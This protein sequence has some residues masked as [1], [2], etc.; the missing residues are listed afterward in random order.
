MEK[1]LESMF[2]KQYEELKEELELKNKQIEKLEAKKIEA[3]KEKKVEPVVFKTF[4]KECCRLEVIS[5]YG[6]KHTSHFKNLTSEQIKEI[7]EDD[8]KVKE[9]AK[10]HDDYL[11]YN[12]E[13]LVRISTACFPYSAV[14]QGHVVLMRVSD[15]DKFEAYAF[16]LADK[17]NLEDNRWFDIKEKE[18][19]YQY[20][21]QLFKEKLKEVYKDKLIS[22]QEESK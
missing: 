5:S 22:E 6:I 3:D 9:Y 4:S 10:L 19:L 15:Y 16:V 8:E 18:R 21:L 12:N 20:G 14:I 11:S 2:I 17:N 1:S 7:F 13:S